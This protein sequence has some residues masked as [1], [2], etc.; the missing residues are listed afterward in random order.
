MKDNRF[1]ISFNEFCFLV[2]ACMPPTN[3]KRLAFWK[4]VIDVYYHK[5]TPDEADNLYMWISHLDDYNYDNTYW[6]FFAA[7]YNRRNQYMVKLKNGEVYNAFAYEGMF[8]KG[9]EL[10]ISANHI[11]NVNKVDVERSVPRRCPVPTHDPHTGKLPTYYVKCLE[12]NLDP[13]PPVVTPMV[14]PGVTPIRYKNKK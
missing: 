1:G 12:N 6:K 11:E 5:L 4:E 9:Y 13:N 3:E 14:T 2:A 10:P 8:Y 7:R